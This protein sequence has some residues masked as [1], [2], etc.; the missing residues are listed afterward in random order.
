MWGVPGPGEWV[1]ELVCDDATEPDIPHRQQL[2]V[3][4]DATEP[5]VRARELA[6]EVGWAETEAALRGTFTAIIEHVA[7]AV[8][9][10]HG[11]GLLLRAV[12][13]IRTTAKWLE[14]G[15]GRRG[16]DVEVPILLGPDFELDLYV[17][18]GQSANADEPPITVCFAP[19]SGPDPG[20]LVIDGCEISPGDAAGEEPS[21]GDGEAAC[22]AQEP[23][24]EK[25]CGRSAEDEARVVLVDLD[26]SPLMSREP[27]PQV[28]AAVLMHL[29]KDQLLPELKQQQLWDELKAAGVERVVYY[30]Q[31]SKDSVWL[32]LSVTEKKPAQARIALDSAGRLLPWVI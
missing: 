27:D 5:D 1:G 12:E 23:E 3:C 29:A 18:A 15:D 9:D 11:L 10:V 7:Q 6:Q 16:V 28:R 22:R 20:V 26:L 19:I 2:L 32:F 4:D 24:V 21:D 17:H 30:D 31:G 25:A 8:A 14:V 13:L